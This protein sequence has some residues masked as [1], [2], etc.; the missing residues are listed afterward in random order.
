MVAA[1]VKIGDKVTRIAF[2]N[3][4]GKHLPAVPGLTV[5]S[6]RLVECKSIPSYWRIKAVTDRGGYFEGAARFFGL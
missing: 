2:T 5:E 1:P 4:F 6:V 3:C